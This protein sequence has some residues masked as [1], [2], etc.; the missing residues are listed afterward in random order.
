MFLH[1]ILNENSKSLIR[2]FLQAQI[3][4]PA[5]NDWVHTVRENLEELEIGLEFNDI[6]ILSKNSFKTFIDKKIE[7]R[8]LDYLIEI[9]NEHSKVKHIKYTNLKL[10][11]YFRSPEHVNMDI[12]KFI[13]HARTRMLDV[14]ENF[15]NKY[16]KTIS[17][18]K[19]PLGCA[20]LDKQEHLLLCTKIEKNSLISAKYQ[21]KYQDLFSQ[22]S[23]KQI[24]IALIL[25]ERLSRRKIL[26]QKMDRGEPLCVFSSA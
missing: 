22:D 7:A 24:K 20:D 11:N 2:Q 5:K 1:Y 13:F 3:L 8:V 6:E 14:R 18:T 19:C 26:I 9:K 17:H 21:P 16:I 10:Q 4:N 25:Q 23:E 12:P 15:K